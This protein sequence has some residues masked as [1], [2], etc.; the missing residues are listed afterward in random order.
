VTGALGGAAAGL[1]RLAE[2]AAKAHAARLGPKGTSGRIAPLRIPRQTATAACAASLSAAAHQAGTVA[3]ET[4]IASAAIEFERRAFHRPGASCARSQ[5]S[6]R[7]SMRGAACSFG[8]DSGTG[9]HGARITNCCSRLRRRRG[10]H[11]GSTEFPSRA[12]AASFAGAKAGRRSR[13]VTAQGRQAL[14]PRGWEHFC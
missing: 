2:L 11:A 9:S 4:R 14:A 10:C 3:G 13:L 12:S 6:Q 1:A 5:L 8:R 7:K